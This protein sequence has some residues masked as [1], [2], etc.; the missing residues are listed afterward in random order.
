MAGRLAWAWWPFALLVLPMAPG[1]VKQGAARSAHCRS[2][3]ATTTADTP[4][5]QIVNSTPEPG[6]TDVIAALE[7]ITVTFDRDMGKAA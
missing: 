1:T 7:E 4:Y 2:I 3:A 6:A 5:P